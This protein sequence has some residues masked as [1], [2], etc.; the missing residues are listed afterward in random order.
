MRFINKQSDRVVIDSGWQ[1]VADYRRAIRTKME[2]LF[3]ELLTRD[4]HVDAAAQEMALL[5][6]DNLKG[7]DY[8]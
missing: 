8:V 7:G 6:N 5:C 3:I 4:Y 1:S 2:A